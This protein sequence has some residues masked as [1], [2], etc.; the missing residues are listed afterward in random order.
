MF[1]RVCVVRFT[2]Y[3]FYKVEGAAKHSITI[4]S[5]HSGRSLSHTMIDVAC[6]AHDTP[7]P[8]RNRLRVEAVFRDGLPMQ[9][10][11][12]GHGQ[13]LLSSVVL[14]RCHPPPDTAPTTR[15]LR[16]GTACSAT[17]CGDACCRP[18]RGSHAIV[19]RRPIHPPVGEAYAAD[20]RLC[21][22]LAHGH[23]GV[24]VEEHQHHK[25]RERHHAVAVRVGE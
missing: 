14:R 11:P 9:V 21:T 1:A 24:L 3:S 19:I 13:P 16:M 4:S 17:S 12:P 10:Y 15:R 7:P 6:T 25:L 22:A 23:G 8:P 5:V 2:L 18:S 20:S